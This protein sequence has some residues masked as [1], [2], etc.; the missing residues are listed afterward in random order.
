MIVYIIVIVLLFYMIYRY[1]TSGNNIHKFYG[2][3]AKN[4]DELRDGLMH[5]KNK[6]IVIYLIY[7][8]YI[9]ST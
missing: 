9:N 8:T 6:L 2:K 5:R 4:E 1:F 7:I 3:I